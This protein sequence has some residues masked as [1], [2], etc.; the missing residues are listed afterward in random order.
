MNNVRSNLHWVSIFATY[1]TFEFRFTLEKT[2]AKQIVLCIS[3]Q[4]ILKYRLTK[5]ARDSF[6]GSIHL[7]RYL[8]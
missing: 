2:L 1:I 5:L 8:H 7:C 3:E 4:E 6:V